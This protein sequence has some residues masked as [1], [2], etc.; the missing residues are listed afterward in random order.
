MLGIVPLTVVM[1][2]IFNNTRRSTLAIILFHF[3][4][5]FTD[6]FLNTTT[7]TNIYST[8]LWILAAALVVFV[9]GRTTL[10]G[11][12]KA[13]MRTPTWLSAPGQS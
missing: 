10:A 2:W 9:W 4:V 12:A 1:T 8:L 6:D 13:E 3:M 5:V 7:R 11:K